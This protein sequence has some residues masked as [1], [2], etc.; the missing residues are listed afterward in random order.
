MKKSF[1]LIEILISIAILSVLFLALSNVISYLSNSSLFIKHKY[2]HTE[3][4][5]RFLK[6]LYYDLLDADYINI[7]QS[8][9]YSF[10]KMRTTNSLYRIPKPYVIWYV[11][12][13]GNSLMRLES[14]KDVNLSVEREYYYLD[15]FAQNVKIF[16]IYQKNG[17]YFVYFDNKKPIYYEM[18]KGF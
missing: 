17:G 13:N 3:N 9:N 14:P 10:V 4:S 18:Y 8:K 1:T 16:K 15:K 2:Q 6:V 11:S 7:K 12:K 5:D